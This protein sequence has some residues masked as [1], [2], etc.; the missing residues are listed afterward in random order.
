MTK[1][2]IEIK[3]EKLTK[4]LISSYKRIKNLDNK[5]SNIL[6]TELK[7]IKN[8]I[9]VVKKFP[10]SAQPNKVDIIKLKKDLLKKYKDHQSKIAK[11]FK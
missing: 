9:S 3:T 5:S 2:K 6:I 7:E 8:F 11:I 4:N 10:K 1:S